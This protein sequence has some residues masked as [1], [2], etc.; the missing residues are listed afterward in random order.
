M[1]L[2]LPSWLHEL[3][4]AGNASAGWDSTRSSDSVSRND[5]AAVSSTR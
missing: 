3:M 2:P 1:K 4:L 5:V